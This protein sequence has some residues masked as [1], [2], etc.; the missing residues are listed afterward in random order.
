LNDRGPAISQRIALLGNPVKNL[1]P[2]SFFSQWQIKRGL[3]SGPNVAFMS[4]AV[5]YQFA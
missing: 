2:W 3:F 1:F 4:P 5:V